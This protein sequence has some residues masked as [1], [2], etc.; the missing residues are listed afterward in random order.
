MQEYS[1]LQKECVSELEKSFSSGGGKSTVVT[2]QKDYLNDKQIC[3]TSVA[4][5]PNN[6]T[7]EII[8]KIIRPLKEIEPEHFYFPPE[9]M[10]LTIKNVRTIHNPPLFDQADI[11]NV[12]ELFSNIIPQFPSF[13][14]KVEEVLAFPTSISVMAYSD[15]TLQK[16]VYSLDDGLKKI[17]VPDD[18]KYLSNSVFWGN[19]TVCRLVKK[20]GDRFIEA[21]RKMR[22]MK[23]GQFKIK[24]INLITSNVVISPNSKTVIAEYN[25]RDK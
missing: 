15:D 3:L 17:G 24:K 13:E 16:L 1:K 19:I 14:F 10:H 11:D 12:N 22:D 9:S 8:E 20:P 7:R 25:L 2:M 6:I 23:I 21:I 18:K 5:L 4:F